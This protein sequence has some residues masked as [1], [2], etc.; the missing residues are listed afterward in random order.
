MQAIDPR[1]DDHIDETAFAKAMAETATAA[2]DASKRP[3]DEQQMGGQLTSA[4]GMGEIMVASGVV[5]ATGV[6]PSLG[7]GPPRTVSGTPEIL[8]IRIRYTKY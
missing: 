1:H 7:F 4:I 3:T 8:R 2:K 6:L 5:I